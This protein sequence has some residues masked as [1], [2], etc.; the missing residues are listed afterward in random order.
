MGTISYTH[1]PKTLP[2]F[3]DDHDTMRS[4]YK[5][6]GEVTKPENRTR[7]LAIRSCN[8]ERCLDML[9]LFISVADSIPNFV[10]IISEPFIAVQYDYFAIN[11][12][13]QR[14]KQA[15]SGLL[16]KILIRFIFVNPE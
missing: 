6:R 15:A 16:Y 9:S 8:S 14:R 11:V 12:S 13:S 7:C 5:S 4:P 10:R 2:Y 1:V 3:Q